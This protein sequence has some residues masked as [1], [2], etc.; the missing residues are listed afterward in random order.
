MQWSRHGRIIL[1][2]AC[3][4]L[5][6][7]KP[8]VVGA[9]VVSVTASS[10]PTRGCYRIINGNATTL[11]SGSLKIW[12]TPKK[13]TAVSERQKDYIDT[14]KSWTACKRLRVQSITA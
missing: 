3:S 10:V 8:E 2:E 13:Y 5:L 7:A 12:D 14:L 6:P 1:P 9:N 11:G 4:P